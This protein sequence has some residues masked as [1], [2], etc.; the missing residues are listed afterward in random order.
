MA[1]TRERMKG[2]ASHADFIG[3]SR[4]VANSV[5]FMTLPPIARALYVDL[6]RQY[7]G[8]NNGDICA[9]DGVLA[10]YGWSHSTVHKH[11]KVLLNRGL[12][13]KTRQGGFAAMSRTPCLY[14][15]T[16]EVIHAN[17]SKGVSGAMPT[18]DYRKYQVEASPLNGKNKSKVHNVTGNVQI[19]NL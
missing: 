11:L 6:R 12:I 8:H 18:F 15:F 4:D 2:R 3:I 7:N 17:P 9:V 19:V 16:D 13:V 1:R 10:K 5:A 14:G